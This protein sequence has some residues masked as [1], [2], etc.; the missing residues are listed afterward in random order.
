[1]IIKYKIIKYIWPRLWS[2]NYKH[3]KYNHCTVELAILG[4]MSRLATN[5]GTVSYTVMLLY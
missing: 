4:V 2:P 3:R 5:R 1:M